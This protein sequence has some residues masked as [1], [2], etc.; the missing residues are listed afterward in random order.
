MPDAIENG[1][2]SEPVEFPEFNL[3]VS[4]EDPAPGVTD[5]APTGTEPAQQ[6][7]AN[8]AWE[9]LKEKLPK[10]FHSQIDPILSEWDKGVQQKFQQHAEELRKYEAWNEFVNAGIDPQALRVSHQM[11][12]NLNSDPLTFYNNLANVL[13]ENGLIKEAAQAQ[14]KADEELENLEQVQDPRV[15]QLAAQQQEL[16]QRLEAEQAAKMQAEADQRILQQVESEMEALQ[17][18]TGPLPDWVKDEVFR[19]GTM[20]TQQLGRPVSI[21]E[22]FIDFQKVRQQLANTPR[23]G[24]T[25]PRVVSGGGG[26]PAPKPNPEAL[27][28]F[29]GR[30]AAIADIIN[31]EKG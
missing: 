7:S 20:L 28:S 24:E 15:D 27:K 26:F 5:P 14:A 25:A 1:G 13:R 2:T 3:D 10:E 11:A 8:P 16:I 18:K 29:E 31:R 12:Q 4:L 6:V 17:A 21:Q 22:A 19:R 9:T 30:T 23:P